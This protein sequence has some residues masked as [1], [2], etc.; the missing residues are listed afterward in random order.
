MFKSANVKAT[1]PHFPGLQGD[2]LT[3]ASLSSAQQLD[4]SETLK[5]PA[6]P[7]TASKTEGLTELQCI[8]YPNWALFL[9][10]QRKADPTRIDASIQRLQ[11]LAFWPF[12]RSR[13]QRQG[14]P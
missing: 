9:A 12:S 6:N 4:K 8:M 5:K 3:L 11:A 10:E 2:L 13:R 14:H 7:A 1:H